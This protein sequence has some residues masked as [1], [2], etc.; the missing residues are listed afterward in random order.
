MLL[1]SMLFMLIATIAMWM[2]LQKWAPDYESTNSARPNV[3]V[4]EETGFLAG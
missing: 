4:V 2:E 3:M 1:L